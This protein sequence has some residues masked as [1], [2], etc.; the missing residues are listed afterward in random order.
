MLKRFNVS[1]LKGWN[2]RV[3]LSNAKHLNLPTYKYKF[4]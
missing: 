3:E 1:M 4:S 2:V